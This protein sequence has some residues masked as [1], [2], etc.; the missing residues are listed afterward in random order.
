MKTWALTDLL[1]KHLAWEHLAQV[2]EPKSTKIQGHKLK[3]L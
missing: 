1:T 3:L 2:I